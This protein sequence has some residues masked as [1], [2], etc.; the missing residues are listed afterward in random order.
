MD[1][2]ATGSSN[3]KEANPEKLTE[4]QP[5]ATLESSDEKNEYDLLDLTDDDFV[6]DSESEVVDVDSVDTDIF[7]T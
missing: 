4:D 5:S 3:P 1:K 7:A 2:S 6:L